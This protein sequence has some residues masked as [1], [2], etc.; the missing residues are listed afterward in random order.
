MGMR[1]LGGQFRGRNIHMPFGRNTRPTGAQMRARVFNIL[2][3]A[4]WAPEWE[5]A[6]VI[7]IFAGSGALGFEALSR[8]ADFCLFVETSTQARA[9]I[10]ATIDDFGLAGKTRLHR[11]DAT[12]LRVQPGNLRGAF[13]HVFLDPPY[14]KC[15]GAPVLRKLANQGLIAPNAVIV[16]EMAHDEQA[17]T[18]GIRGMFQTQEIRIHGESQLVFACFM[19]DQGAQ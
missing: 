11:Y 2:S 13:T 5:G 9:G 1:V 16:Y 17:H 10:R 8:G 3:H 14:R 18:N 4:S 19:P 7:D 15:L 12:K 6:L